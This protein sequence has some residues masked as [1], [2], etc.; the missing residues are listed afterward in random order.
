MK[1]CHVCTHPRTHENKLSP[2]YIDFHRLDV[3]TCP[4]HHC[5]YLSLDARKKGCIELRRLT[6]HMLPVISYHSRRTNVLL[7]AQLE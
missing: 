1:K 5:Q 7:T 2:N 4:R 6:I 3:E